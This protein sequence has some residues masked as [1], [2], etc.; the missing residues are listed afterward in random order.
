MSS[1]RTLPDWIRAHGGPILSGRIR[2]SPQD[3]AVTEILGFEPDGMGEHDFLWLEKVNANTAWV[4][5]QLAAFARIPI[6]DVGYSGMKDRRAVSRQWFSVR[7]PAGERADWSTLD[8]EGVRVLQCTRNSRKLRRGAHAG[9]YFCLVVREIEGSVGRLD[10]VVAAIAKVGVPNYFGE[11]R[12][13][14]ECRNLKLV[15]ALFSGKRMQRDKRSIGLSAARSWIFNHVLQQRVKDQSWSQFQQ[16]DV[17]ILDGSNSIFAVDEI[18]NCLIQR[19]EQLDL[20]PSGPLWGKS[21]SGGQFESDIAAHFADLATGLEIHTKMSR[22]A[23]RLAVREMKATPTDDTLKL[24]F[25]LARGGFATAVL[26]E[27]VRYELG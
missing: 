27:M 7:R 19:C 16:G 23:L 10:D 24:E 13:G 11:Q 26:R 20:H 2:Q 14:R 3:F 1:E 18:D 5:R 22:R 9:N 25:Y 17:A 15:E 6:R 21:G 8:I 12:F 4:A